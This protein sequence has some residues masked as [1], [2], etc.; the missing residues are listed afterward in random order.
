M[1]QEWTGNTARIG[2]ARAVALLCIDFHCNED[3]GAKQ[4]IFHSIFPIARRGFLIEL[5]PLQAFIPFGKQVQNY[6]ESVGRI[7]ALMC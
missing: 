3:C 7:W 4:K 6:L 1:N 5:F 2:L